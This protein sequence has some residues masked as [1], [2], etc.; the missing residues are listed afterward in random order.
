MRLG[1]FGGTFSPPH[2]GHLSA[3]SAFLGEMR[4]DSLLVIPVAIP[5]HKQADGLADAEHRLAMCRLTFGS[6]DRTEI[7]DLEIR[8][9]GKSYTYLTLQEL[10]REDN[11][12]FLLC[13]TDMAMTLDSWVCPEE[14]FALSHIVV[15]SRE[16]DPSEKKALLEKLEE[17]KSKYGARI[18]VLSNPVIEISPTELRDMVAGGKNTERYLDPKVRRYIDEWK[19]YQPIAS[20]PSKN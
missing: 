1:I 19:L 11:E 18:T 12:L 7:S 20:K 13:G 10:K 2:L 14:I 17:Y 15:A 16:L 9:A 4:L 3:V 5:P 8:R 6:L